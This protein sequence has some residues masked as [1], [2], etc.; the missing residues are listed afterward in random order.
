MAQ[1]KKR[2]I[3]KSQKVANHLLKHGSITSWEAIKLYKATRLS[4]I[5][6]NYRKKDWDIITEEVNKKDENGYPCTFAK[7]ILLGNPKSV[8]SVGNK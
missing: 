3:S 6:F 1:P 2:G 7:Y 8:S 5:I 4:A